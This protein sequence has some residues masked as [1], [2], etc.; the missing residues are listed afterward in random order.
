MNEEIKTADVAENNVN[1]VTETVTEIIRTPQEEEALPVEELTEELIKQH[2]LELDQYLIL[3]GYSEVSR[4]AI[5]IAAE[6]SIYN[7]NTVEYC[8][9][10]YKILSAAAVVYNPDYNARS[11]ENPFVYYG[12]MSLAK[13]LIT[14]YETTFG[15]ISQ[16]W[17]QMINGTEPLTRQ[18][19]KVAKKLYQ[20]LHKEENGTE[21]HNDKAFI[22]VLNM[23]LY[24]YSLVFP[25]QVKIMQ[26][27]DREYAE[28]HNRFNKENGYSRTPRFNNV[29]DAFDKA[30]DKTK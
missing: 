26:E 4:R 17:L 6:K 3:A 15:H 16:R 24:M 23:L 8:T 9:I 27:R 7:E 21:E 5:K 10:G 30:S 11:R 12:L 19:D 25:E 20:C 29:K 18:S 2:L 13:R 22:T 28:K 14:T 1:T